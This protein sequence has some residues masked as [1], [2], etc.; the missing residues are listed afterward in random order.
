MEH[1]ELMFTSEVNENQKK[2]VSKLLFDAFREKFTYIWHMNKSEEHTLEFLYHNLNYNSCLYAIYEDNVVGVLGMDNFKGVKLLQ[3]SLKSQIESYGILGGLFRQC[4][5]VV[6]RIFFSSKVDS[7]QSRVYPIAVSEKTR[8]MGIGKA[9]LIKFEEYLKERG[10]LSIALEVID[11][12]PRA[13]KLYEKM[14]YVVIDKK[15]TS[16]FTKEAGF[17]YMYFMTKEILMSK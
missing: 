16:F 3:F 7:K 15:R 4:I 12:N 1:N 11:T 2:Q 8:G 14:G 6:E 9:L 5:Q 13:K 17:D 10:I